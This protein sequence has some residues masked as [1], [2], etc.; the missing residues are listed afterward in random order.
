MT[1]YWF[2][3]VHLSSAD[4]FKTAQW[5]ADVFGAEVINPW[6]DPKGVGHVIVNLKGANIFVKGRADK[7][8]VEPNSTRAYGLE[9]IAILTDDLDSAVA[10]LKGKGIRFVEDISNTLLANVRHAFIS[11]PEDILIELIERK[12]A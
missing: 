9:H 5:F 10:Q 11:G 3:H 2:D 8:T 6:T 12:S 4:P 1:D 7:P